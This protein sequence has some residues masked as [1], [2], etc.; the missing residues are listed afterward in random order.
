MRNHWNSSLLWLV[1]LGVFCGC[2]S[3]GG[4]GGT[5]FIDNP[6]GGLAATF[7]PGQPSPSADEVSM[8][9]SGT[10][11]NLV[12]VAVNLT[13]VED[14]FG[15]SFDVDYDSARAEYVSFSPGNLFEAGGDTPLYT[16]NSQAGRVVVGVA[17]SSGVAGGVDV[18]GTD[19]I[20]RL[21]FRMTSAGTASLGFDHETLLDDQSPPQPITGLSWSGGNLQAN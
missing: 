1:A 3:S 20:V 17:R 18:N 12:T 19:T 9:E 11:G 2:S 15:A 7:T 16:I 10:S 6:G 21:T 14:V 8:A 13:N 4:G 5:P